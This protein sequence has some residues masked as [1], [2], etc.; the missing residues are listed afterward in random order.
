M[1][2]RKEEGEVLRNAIWGKSKV[3][4]RE[5]KV[6]LGGGR[7]SQI[8]DSKNIGKP[9]LQMEPPLNPLCRNAPIR[10]EGKFPL[11]KKGQ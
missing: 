4:Q 3:R 8:R 11:K 1:E 10:E 9:R 7:I 2:E 6:S 5:K